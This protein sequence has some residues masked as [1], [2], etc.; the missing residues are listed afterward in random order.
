M[1]FDPRTPFN[2]LPP[3]PPQVDVETNRILKKL[4]S[5]RG[6]IGEL[7]GAVKLI[8][9][10]T[11]LLNTLIMEEARDSSEIENIFTT[12]DKM[13]KAMALRGAK[14]DPATKEV[15]RYRESLWRGF[16]VVRKQKKLSNELIIQLQK[17]LIEK[18]TGIRKKPGTYIGNR[19]TGEVTYTPPDGE[20]RIR[21]LLKNLEIYLTATDSIDPLIKLGVIHYQF[22]AIHPFYW[23]KPLIRSGKRHQRSIQKNW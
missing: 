13:Y 11:I 23:I 15:L 12:R 7:K 1:A 21:D 10:Q 6:V 9:N 14:I 22:E 20:H 8:P 2:D 18:N 17:S 5:A 19:L 3:L 4:A 16:N